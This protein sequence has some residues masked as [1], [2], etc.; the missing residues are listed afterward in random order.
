[1]ACRIM[2]EVFYD[3][4]VRSA[5]AVIFKNKKFAREWQA[6][7]KNPKWKLRVVE[8]CETRGKVT[9]RGKRSFTG[10]RRRR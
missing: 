8:V 6:E 7:R 3:A 1:M 9:R 10:R 4:P 5:A 2:Y